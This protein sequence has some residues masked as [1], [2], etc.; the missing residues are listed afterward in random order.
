MQAGKY[1]ECKICGHIGYA[2]GI[3]TSFGV[4]CGFCQKCGVNDN[5]IE[6]PLGY[7]KPNWLKRIYLR[8]TT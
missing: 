6:V 8:F 2:Y 5:L 7:K 4:S 1:C 3:P